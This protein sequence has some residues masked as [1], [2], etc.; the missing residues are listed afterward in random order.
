MVI[1]HATSETDATATSSAATRPRYTVTPTWS[2]ASGKYAVAI[3]GT[4]LGQAQQPRAREISYATEY[5]GVHL[6]IAACK[7]TSA[8]L[9]VPHTNTYD[10]YIDNYA[11]ASLPRPARAT[12]VQQRQPSRAQA[13]PQTRVAVL[14]GLDLGANQSVAHETKLEG[15]VQ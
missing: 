6:Q 10:L 8:A 2:K 14:N 1:L 12:L 11:F 3:N 13:Q 9:G 4:T 15:K 7:K 5:Q